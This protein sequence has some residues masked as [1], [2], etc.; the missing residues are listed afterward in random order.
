MWKNIAESDRP[1]MAIRRMSTRCGITKATDTDSEYI[2]L[3]AFPM[4]QWIRERASVCCVVRPLPVSS[5]SVVGWLRRTWDASTR[6]LKEPAVYM[7]GKWIL[8]KWEGRT[9]SGFIWLRTGACADSCDRGNEPWGAINCRQRL[10]SWA[11]LSG[12]RE[13]FCWHM[14]FVSDTI[15]YKKKQPSRSAHVDTMW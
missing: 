8:K 1:Q 11:Q 15:C 13:G 14:E 5:Y 10:A 9:H 7:E 4:Q 12:S 3:I 6:N 2:I